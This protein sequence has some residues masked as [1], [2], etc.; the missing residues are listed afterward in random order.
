MVSTEET[1]P[2][3]C[4]ILPQGK[5]R[6]ILQNDSFPRTVESFLGFP[7]AQAPIEDLRFRP[8]ARLPSSSDIFDASVYGRAAPGKPLIPPRIPLVYSED[9]LTVNVFRQAGKVNNG[10]LLPVAIYIHGGA[11]NRGHSSMQDT[12]SMV[13]WSEEPFIAVSFNYRVGALGFLPST[14]SAEEGILNLGIQDQR[15]LL[16]WVQ[17]NIHHFGGDKSN[18]TVM[19]LSAGAITVSDTVPMMGLRLTPETAWT[20]PFPLQRQ[21]QSSLSQSNHPVRL[22][23]LERLSTIQLKDH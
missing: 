22:T 6:G 9:C 23:N 13:A 10:T 8:P 21:A 17:E 12:A 15:F 20:F 11:F 18:V 2:R 16:E 3:P 14:R 7:Y 4:V 5:I 1:L 19:G